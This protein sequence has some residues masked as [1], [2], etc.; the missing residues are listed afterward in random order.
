MPERS[1]GVH[2]SCTVFVLV[3]SNP[4]KCMPQPFTRTAARYHQT[5]RK[6]ALLLYSKDPVR[7]LRGSRQ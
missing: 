6:F 3:G 4:T 5:K 2:S 7:I 1:K